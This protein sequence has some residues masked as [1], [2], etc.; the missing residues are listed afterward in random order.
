MIN[1]RLKLWKRACHVKIDIF[2]RFIYL[3][4]SEKLRQTRVVALFS[5]NNRILPATC[6]IKINTLWKCYKAMLF[7]QFWWSLWTR[8]C[9]YMFGVKVGGSRL[10][11]T[12]CLCVGGSWGSREFFT[13]TEAPYP[14]QLTSFN[15]TAFY[16]GSQTHTAY[17]RP[18]AVWMSHY[19]HVI[20]HPFNL[21]LRA[22]LSTQ[23]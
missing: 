23:L 21:F 8:G 4:R 15:F 7:W 10:Q 13:F 6:L 5:Q 1:W 20:S 17:C 16:T 22:I 11:T 19:C 12:R 3:N 14:L 2:E 9:F 18:V